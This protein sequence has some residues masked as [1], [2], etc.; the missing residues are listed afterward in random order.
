MTNATLKALV[1]V[2]G[3]LVKA[4]WG[5]PDGQD[6][7]PTPPVHG[8]PERPSQVEQSTEV[9]ASHSPLGTQKHEAII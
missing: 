9:P 6:T 4:G 8:V 5:E 2:Y 3:T 1:D 7:E